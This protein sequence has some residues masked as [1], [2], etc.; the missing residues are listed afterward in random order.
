MPSKALP[1]VEDLPQR[2]ATYVKTK[3]PYLRRKVR[4]AGSVAI[5]RHGKI[6]A[7]MMD[8][9]LYR[10]MAALADAARKHGR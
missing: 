4:S 6:A 9:T 8:A 3:W 5:T 7:V 2:S 10:E 1:S